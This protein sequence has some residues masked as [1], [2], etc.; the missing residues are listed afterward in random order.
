MLATLMSM[1]GSPSPGPSLNSARR[2]VT[3][4]MPAMTQ[5]FEPLPLASSTFTAQMR[6]PGATPTTPRSLSR[7]RDRPGDVGAVAV[8]VFVRRVGAAVRR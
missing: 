5:E 4:S 2:S 1:P 7:A 6:A 3:Q 8:V